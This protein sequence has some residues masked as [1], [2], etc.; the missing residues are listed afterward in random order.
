MIEIVTKEIISI[1]NNSSYNQ[2]MKE[3]LIK[4]TLE[5]FE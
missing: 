3:A 2:A 4:Q 5:L 1:A